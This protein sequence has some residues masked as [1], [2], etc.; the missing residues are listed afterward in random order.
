MWYVCA[1]CMWKISEDL[2]HYKIFISEITVNEW[3]TED[4]RRNSEGLE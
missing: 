3:K 1:L 2:L 4:L